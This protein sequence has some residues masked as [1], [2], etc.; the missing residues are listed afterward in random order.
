MLRDAGF[1]GRHFVLMG[2]AGVLLSAF[3]VRSAQAGE[4]T[5]TWTGHW[6]SHTNGHNGPMTAR[7]KRINASQYRVRFTGFFCTVIPF[8]YSETFDV[9]SDDGQT[10]Q[11]SASSKLCFF[12]TFHCRAAANCCHFNANY[13]AE[14]DQGYFALRRKN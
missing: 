11:L 6:Y 13:A 7:F 9:I 5:G 14:S 3:A 1:R 4:L 10:V 8:C 2:L 12:G